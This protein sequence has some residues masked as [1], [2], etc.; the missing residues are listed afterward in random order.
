MLMHKFK[1]KQL[2]KPK[3]YFNYYYGLTFCFKA[4]YEQKNVIFIKTNL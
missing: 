1:N 3:K 2:F 4:F